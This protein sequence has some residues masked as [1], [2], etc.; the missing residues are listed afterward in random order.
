MS[1]VPT[2]AMFRYVNDSGAT[3]QPKSA[4]ASVF[5]VLWDGPIDASL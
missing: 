5:P 3:V 4:A 1:L 2:A